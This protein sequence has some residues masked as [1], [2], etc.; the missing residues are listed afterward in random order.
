MDGSESE[1][2]E[3]EQMKLARENLR[4]CFGCGK[5]ANYTEFVFS[6]NMAVEH[7]KRFCKFAQQ[8]GSFEKAKNF[9]EI[10]YK[11]NLLKHFIKKYCLNLAD[12]SA[13]IHAENELE[14][15]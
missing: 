7:K 14:K 1:D 5:I 3:K 2:M 10:E 11:I 4:K 9:A 13:Q 12:E 6:K 8:K 15:I